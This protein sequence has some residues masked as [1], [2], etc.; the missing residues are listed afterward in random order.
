MKSFT[1]MLLG[2]LATCL[3]TYS[4]NA[5]VILQYHHV[6]D[7]TP[8]S[9]SISPQQFAKHMQYLADNDFTVLPLNEVVDAIKQQQPLPNKSVVITF[10]DAYLNI[11]ENAKPIL[12]QHQFPFTIFIN[13]GIVD[14]G[15]AHYLSWSQLKAM[16]DDGVMIANHGFEHESWTRVPK[17]TNFNTWLAQKIALLKKAEAKIKTETGQSWQYFAYPYGEFSPRIQQLLEQNQFIAF[18]QQSGA[19]G[20]D[21]DLTSI[22]RFPA[23]QPYDKLSSLKDKLHSLPL[24]VTLSDQDA[25]TIYTKGALKNVTMTINSD[26]IRTEQL[27][28]YVTSVGKQP[29][30][31]LED[32]QLS[33]T[34]TETLP[35][36]R[37]RSNCTAPSISQPGRYYWYSK[38]WF[39]LNEDGSWYPH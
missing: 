5:S 39:I 29:V 36:G 25:Q 28:C 23:S 3:F 38:P 1:S 31:W 12:D 15:S 33:I 37:V 22:P 26:D 21:T 13:P 20:Q 14:K 2:L 35:S 30:K 19:V 11:L 34:F 16:A 32:K 18:S 8:K 6:S 27:N 10:D 9:T 4:T 24:S 17:D 7:D